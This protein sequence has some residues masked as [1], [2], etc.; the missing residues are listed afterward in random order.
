MMAL[1]FDVNIAFL[2]WAFDK[3]IDPEIAFAAGRHVVGS[4]KKRRNHG[5][6]G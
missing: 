2:C 3:T 1:F 5:I 6:G 4:L